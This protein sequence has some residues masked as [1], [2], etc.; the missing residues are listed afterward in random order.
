MKELGQAQLPNSRSMETNV[1]MLQTEKM[2]TGRYFRSGLALRATRTS[3]G[4]LTRMR[5]FLGTEALGTHGSTY[6]NT[7]KITIPISYIVYIACFQVY[8]THFYFSSCR[9]LNPANQDLS[10]PIIRVSR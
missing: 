3:N 9:C 2:Q 5:P 6:T 8:Y 7:M 4:E 10:V 1:W